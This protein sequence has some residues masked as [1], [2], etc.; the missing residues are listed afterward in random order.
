[1]GFIMHA[2]L[3]IRHGS[4]TWKEKKILKCAL[5]FANVKLHVR[6]GFD[7]WQVHACHVVTLC[8]CV[9]KYRTTEPGY[10]VKLIGFA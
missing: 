2:D 9:R 10:H 4:C 7:P 6:C 3:A 5:T 8:L 1:M